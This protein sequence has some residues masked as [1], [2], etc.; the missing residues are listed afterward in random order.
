MT[1]TNEL[2]KLLEH[3]T[4]RPWM[5]G[6]REL[7]CPQGRYLSV[8]P[9]VDESCQW[10]EEDLALVIAAVNG[11]PSLLDELDAAR[12]NLREAVQ[13]LRDSW[14]EIGRSYEVRYEAFMAKH[15]ETP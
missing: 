4:P 11:L 12:A 13:L 7:V 10:R 14:G 5:D 2:R 9:T 6:N 3:A 8:W 15:K 1:D